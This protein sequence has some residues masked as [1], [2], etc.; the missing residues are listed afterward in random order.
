MTGSLEE[1]YDVTL[2]RLKYNEKPI[3][4]KDVKDK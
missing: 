3:L 2:N 4:L 1:M